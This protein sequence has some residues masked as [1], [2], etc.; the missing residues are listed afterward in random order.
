MENNDNSVKF[1]NKL[2]DEN[3]KN[4]EVENY[5]VNGIYISISTCRY[6]N[7]YKDIFKI[8]HTNEN[9]QLIKLNA[10]KTSENVYRMFTS[11]YKSLEGLKIPVLYAEYSKAN[12]N[13]KLERIAQSIARKTG[14]G[15]YI[16]YQHQDIYCELIEDG[17]LEIKIDFRVLQ[18]INDVEELI[19]VVANDFIFTPLNNYTKQVGY[20]FTLFNNFYSDNVSINSLNYSYIVDYKK[21]INLL[22]YK[23]CL[24]EVFTIQSGKIE[25]NDDVIELNYK[26]VSSYTLMGDIEAYISRLVQNNIPLKDIVVNVSNTF[27]ITA[28]IKEKIE[29]WTSER[30]FEVESGKK[31]KIKDNSV[32]G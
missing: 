11:N 6:E 30:N 4:V 29:E 12:A 28:K 3:N 9:I 16:K 31:I 24:S 7:I 32:S 14:I 25:K 2:V 17:T 15:F 22:K 21:K 23:K 10:G 1:L 27:N 26:R 20:T 13:L 19:S 8:L 18:S 5:G